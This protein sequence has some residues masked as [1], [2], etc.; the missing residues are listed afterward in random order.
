MKLIQKNCHVANVNLAK[1]SLVIHSFGN[2]SSRIDDKYFTIKPSG[3]N[4]NILKHTDYPIIR[5]SD[6]KIIKGKLNPS[7][8]TPTHCLLYKKYPEI[9]GI[10]HTHSKFATAWSQAKKSIPILG[11]TH[12]DYSQKNIQVTNPLKKNQ[13]IKNYEKN[14]GNSIIDCLKKSKIKPLECPGILVANHAPFSF[15]I[16]ANQAFK[17]A[18]ILEYIAE[19]AYLSLQINSKS[20]IDINLIKKHFFRKHGPTSY[21]GQK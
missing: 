5:I 13:I 2:I 16:D 9:G 4:L 12:A 20:K 1:S 17:N 7:T 3:A 11:T 8:D 10:A 6:N 15:G 19:V 14:I 18:E 21:Y